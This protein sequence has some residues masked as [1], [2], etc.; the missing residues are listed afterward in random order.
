M[1]LI[2][3]RFQETCSRGKTPKQY[4]EEIVPQL[5]KELNLTNVMECPK[6]VKIVLNMR[7]GKAT[8][9]SKAIE[10]AV[11]DMEAITGQS[12]LSPKLKVHRKLQAS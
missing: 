2:R 3:Q 1:R 9:D 10:E 5:M 4:R 12:L 6:L 8:S 11:S 7:V